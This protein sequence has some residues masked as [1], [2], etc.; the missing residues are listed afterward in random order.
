M[1]VPVDDFERG[2]ALTQAYH[3]ATG[4]MISVLRFG[5]HMM[6]L[7]KWFACEPLK[8]GQGQRG[9]IR[10]WLRVNAPEINHGTAYRLKR[11]ADEIAEEYESLVG[12][13]FAKQL[14]MQQL[15][16]TDAAKLP[17]DAKA[18]Q[19]ELFD[20][21]RGTSQRS[22]LDRWKQSAR[23]GGNLYDRDGEKGKR[24]PLSPEQ[25]R[26]L[27][28]KLC[29]TTAEHLACVHKQHAITV[30][31]DAEIDGLRDHLQTV[32][33]SVKNWQRLTPGQRQDQ[34]AAF[35]TA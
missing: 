32:L 18:K 22:W 16:L 12:K 19:L 30:L 23:K 3:D 15:V 17:E 1:P 29:T 24:K 7:D 20:F 33:D 28:H 21:V 10:E 4:G 2:Y 6:E 14:T 13:R 26:A 25:H 31:S 27:L 9:G 11:V 8:M 5:A 34:L 35:I